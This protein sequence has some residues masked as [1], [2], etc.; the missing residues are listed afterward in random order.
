MANLTKKTLAPLLA[1]SLILTACADTDSGTENSTTTATTETTAQ[2]TT[3]ESAA[4]SIQLG[5][6]D[7][8]FTDRDLRTE[9]DADEAVSITLSSTLTI[10]EEGVY[11]LSGTIENGQVI[12]DADKNAKIQL[13][14]DSVSIHCSDGPA[15]K[16]LSADKVFITLPE[17]SE[18]HLSD[19]S[20]YL[21]ASG[22][23]EPNAVLYSK[24]DLTLQ[25]TGS[26]IVTASYRH[27]ILSKDDL[28]IT[29]GTYTV[30]APENA[31]RGRD[32]VKICGGDFTIVSGNDG[33]QSNNSEELDTRGFILITGGEFDVTSAGDAIQAESE[34]IITGGAGTLTSGGGSTNAA[35]KQSE[36]LGGRTSL[37]T[38]ASSDTSAKGLK[39][40]VSITIEDCD[41]TINSAD[42]AVHSNGNV[43]VN[44]GSFTITTGDDAFHAD[45]VLT[46]NGGAVTVHSSYEGFEGNNVIING[47]EHYITASDDGI[48]AAG[49]ADSSGFGGW[50]GDAFGGSSTASIEINGGYIVI[51]ADGDGVD[52]N[53]AFTMNDG[54]LLV[55]GP[56]NSGNAAL[57]YDGSAEIHGGIVIALGPSGM[58]QGF[59]TASTQCS[60]TISLSGKAGERITVTDSSGA[61]IVSYIPLKNY[62]TAVISTPAM[63]TGESYSV[64]SGG[65]ATEENG[66][67]FT[68][69]GSVSGAGLV[70]E[71]E[72][73]GVVVGGSF[74]GMG[75]TGGMGGG[76]KGRR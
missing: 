9:W 53:S 24:A 11:L 3:S 71:F 4:E 64:L 29:G 20:D 75:G 57:D 28:V 14:L 30:T 60:A 42:D 13:I 58:A 54:V 17:G 12:I 25:G 51:D 6:F 36:Q 56:T 7:L 23:D 39:A 59:G 27:G 10:T 8:E 65:T 46:M 49:G 33:I 73:S 5:S 1:V 18:S 69:S 37:S 15:I 50:G 40:G 74:G 32:C 45:E 22:E 48:N 34:L 16:I 41:F 2:T 62:Q 66:D 55:N 68:A 21:L 72:Q 35:V 19:G 67:G 44:G 63:Q 76:G 70:T 43:T 61:L 52:S 31:I 47:G 26:L 38:E